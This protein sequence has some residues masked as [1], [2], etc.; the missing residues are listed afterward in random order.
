MRIIIYVFV[1][2][3][4]EMRSFIVTYVQGQQKVGGGGGGGQPTS[5]DP[6]FEKLPKTEQG[7]I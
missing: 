7:D 2:V 1:L 6:Q 3:Y 5:W 4:A